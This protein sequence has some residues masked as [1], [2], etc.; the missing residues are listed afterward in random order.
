MK[1]Q[2]IEDQAFDAPE[3]NVKNWIDADGNKI[4]QIRLSD[5]KGKFKVVFCF[6]SWCPGCHSIGFPTLQKM[7]EAFRHNGNV[8]FLAVQTVF[9]G[10]HENTYSK[11][12]E[13]QKKYGLRIPFGHDAGDDGKSRSNFMQ[14]YRTGGTPWF[15]FID[16]NDKVVFADF[17][18]NVDA[19]IEALRALSA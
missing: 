3:F 15:V 5:F 11:M 13:T 19:S 14:G 6:Q 17:H 18:I 4:D 7:V 9:E 12:V 10:H 8:A 16:Q 2:A 1:N